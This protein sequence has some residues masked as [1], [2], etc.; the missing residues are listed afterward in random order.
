MRIIKFRGKQNK[1]WYY[2]SYI[3]PC[4]ILGDDEKYLI[5][6]VKVEPKTIGQF[7][8]LLDKNG[9]EIYENDRISIDYAPKEKGHKYEG[10]VIWDDGGWWV[11]TKVRG[12]ETVSLTGEADLTLLGNIH[13]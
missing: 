12:Y 5:N 13:E 9:K 1:K 6:M 10:V 3:K 7:T 8:G 2:G 4:H 11:K